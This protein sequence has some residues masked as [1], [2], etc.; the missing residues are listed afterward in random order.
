MRKGR[1]RVANTKDRAGP[2]ADSQLVKVKK[3]SCRRIQSPTGRR[4]TRRN[5]PQTPRNSVRAPF[6]ELLEDLWTLAILL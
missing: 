3:S 5:K 4:H 1:Q 2:E 6:P